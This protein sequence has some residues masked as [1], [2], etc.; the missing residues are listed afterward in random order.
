[1]SPAMVGEH[2]RSC[3]GCRTWEQRA[4]TLTRT[5]RVREA[6]PTPD[7]TTRILAAAPPPRH[8]QWWWRFAL[9]VVAA[10]QLWLGISQIFGLDT[11]TTSTPMV[12]P[13]DMSTH[14]FDESTAWNLALGLGLAWVALRVRA[15]AGMLPVLGG[16]LAILTAYCVH[17]LATG[18]V[19]VARVASHGLLPIGFAL[20]WM[21]H[22]RCVP[23]P[24]PRPGPPVAETASAGPVDPAGA[25]V[26]P[27]GT[28]VGPA[29]PAPPAR[30]RR[31]LGR[32]G[33]GRA[34]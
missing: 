34:A 27:A 31:R 8:P 17:D 28:S 23:R 12:M 18:E 15:A 16:F 25:S 21:V 14:L 7:L 26:D 6:T 20:V 33:Q 2:L 24:D 3:A 19:T 9:A 13:G 4:A 10:A 32:A 29:A 5:L 11:G 22:R 30:G 1:V